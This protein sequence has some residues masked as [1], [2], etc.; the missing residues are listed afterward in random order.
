MT[1]CY[2]LDLLH[3]YCLLVFP[4]MFLAQRHPVV[5]GQPALEAHIGFL[6]YFENLF[7]LNNCVMQYML[8][9]L[10]HYFLDW[11]QLCDQK[12]SSGLTRFQKHFQKFDVLVK[13]YSYRPSF[14]QII[15][16]LKLIL[17]IL[18]F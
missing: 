3:G 15:L 10:S 18:N 7:L 1:Y 13:V 16:S 11:L 14:H 8:S 17:E 2:Q 5:L 12:L 4:S 6:A 9:L